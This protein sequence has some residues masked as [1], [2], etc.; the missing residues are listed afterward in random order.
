MVENA[1][2]IL[3][4]GGEIYCFFLHRNVLCV[5][6]TILKIYNLWTIIY[7][8]FYLQLNYYARIRAFGKSKNGRNCQKVHNLTFLQSRLKK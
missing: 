5:N 4:L 6:Q 1:I 2:S 8:T 7:D 3:S